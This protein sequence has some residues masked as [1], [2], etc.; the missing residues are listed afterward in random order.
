M[1]YQVFKRKQIQIQSY[2]YSDFT[3]DIFGMQTLNY[4]SQKRK[5]N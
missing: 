1:R 5:A 2:L 3:S 4:D